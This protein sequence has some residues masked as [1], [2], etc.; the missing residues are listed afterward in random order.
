MVNIF[1]RKKEETQG[2]KPPQPETKNPAPTNKTKEQFAQNLL[3]E[4]NPNLGDILKSHAEEIARLKELPA[5]GHAI[6]FLAPEYRKNLSPVAMLAYEKGYFHLLPLWL[7]EVTKGIDKLG[8]IQIDL[9]GSGKYQN[10]AMPGYFLVE[11]LM[12]PDKAQRFYEHAPGKCTKE[13]F[14]VQ[15]GDPSM[16]PAIIMNPHK[17]QLVVQAAYTNLSYIIFEYKNESEASIFIEKTKEYWATLW[18]RY[19]G[20]PDSAKSLEDDNGLL[21]LELPAQNRVWWRQ[22]N[23][24]LSIC[25][26]GKEGIIESTARKKTIGTLLGMLNANESRLNKMVQTAATNLQQIIDGTSDTGQPLEQ[27]LADAKA[28]FDK[29]Q[30]KEALAKFEEVLQKDPKNADAFRNI[31]TINIFMQ[32]FVPAERNL[33]KAVELNSKDEVAYA[34]LAQLYNLTKK[35]DEAEKALRKALELSP[36]FINHFS[37]ARLLSNQKKCKEALDELE[38]VIKLN[39]KFIQVYPDLLSNLMGSLNIDKNITREVFRRSETLFN[40]GIQ[41][42]PNFYAVHS[43]LGY[44]L[45]FTDRKNQAEREF[46]KALQLNP[47]DQIAQTFLMLKK[48]EPKTWNNIANVCKC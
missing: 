18:K 36:N 23:V 46:L 34:N 32:E 43:G 14:L 20:F 12:N 42:L 38:I 2:P 9:D 10:Y 45:L 33:Q 44:I 39:P 4:K 8:V 26:R 1:G 48:K 47:K 7:G 28:L 11:E 21:V 25:N 15:F 5:L 30:Y 6:G 22:G 24:I 37:L 16:E 35:Y 31:G 40:N 27:I 17:P 3:N 29:K 19:F 41:S 13:E